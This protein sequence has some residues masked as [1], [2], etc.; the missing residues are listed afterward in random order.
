I[1]GGA[2]LALF[3]MIAE[4]GSRKSMIG[5]ILVAVVI[6]GI[7]LNSIRKTNA[8]RFLLMS[9]GALII[10]A[11]GIAYLASSTH[12]DRLENVVAAAAEG[13][14]SASDN[15]LKIRLSLIQFAIEQAADNPLIGTG[16]DN[17]RDINTGLFDEVG[18]YSH[19]NYLEIAVSTGIPGLLLYCSIYALILTKLFRL[20]RKSVV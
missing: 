7:I 5:S 15:S 17:F 19:S 13:N 14:I 4:T 20:D 10:M 8:A 18:T 9:A 2:G 11:G 6:I 12:A 1:L 3:F 16:L